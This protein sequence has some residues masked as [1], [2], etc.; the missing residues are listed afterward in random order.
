MN[1]FIMKT[2]K[3]CNQDKKAQKVGRISE[4][5]FIYYAGEDGRLWLGRLCPDCAKIDRKKYTKSKGYFPKK[6]CLHCSTEF[7]PKRGNAKFCSDNC[8]VTY[9]SLE[10]TRKKHRVASPEVTP[11]PPI[12]LSKRAAKR[13]AE[14]EELRAYKIHMDSVMEKH[15]D[16]FEKL[17]QSELEDVKAT[18]MVNNVEEVGK[19]PED[20][21]E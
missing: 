5:G 13:K 8:A 18:Q 1:D 16:V 14:M 15:K 17:R 9:H 6:N 7:Q 21:V 2:C 10:R 3:Q 4:S 19:K 11:L 12:Q 20:Q